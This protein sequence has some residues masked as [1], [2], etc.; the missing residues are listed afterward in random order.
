MKEKSTV[1]RILNNE[2]SEIIKCEEEES[3]IM[4]KKKKRK[5]IKCSECNN[6]V[7]SRNKFCTGCGNQLIPIENEKKEEIET[8]IEK[9]EKLKLNVHFYASLQP[10]SLLPHHLTEP[11]YCVGT[12]SVDLKPEQ[13]H[14]GFTIVQALPEKSAFFLGSTPD[15]IISQPVMRQPPPLVDKVHYENYGRNLYKLIEKKTSIVMIRVNPIIYSENNL[16]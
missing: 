3:K 4:K 7:S 15:K 8:M 1:K 9:I 13:Y 10:I 2:T 6:R 5:T 12:F 11:I 16:F 14:G